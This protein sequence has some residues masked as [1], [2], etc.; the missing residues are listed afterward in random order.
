MDLAGKVLLVTGGRRVGGELARTLALRG[1][2]VALTYHQSRATIERTVADISSAGGRSIA[3]HADLRAAE[4][5]ERAVE[6]T[7]ARLGR[8]DGLINM[9][10]VYRRTPLD[11]LVPE[12]FDAMIGANLAPAYHTALAAA[13]RMLDQESVVDH[14]LKGKIVLVGDW[15]TERPYKDYLPYL[16]A[17]G[18]PPDADTRPGPRACPVDRREP[19]PARDDR[20]APGP[21]RR[22]YRQH[23]GRDPIAASR[24]P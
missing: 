8:I 20:P 21:D 12:D 11:R 23:R 7:V 22:R 16:V 15:A 18:A 19:R 6:E 10:S 24:M 1:A 17:K 14:T 3:I 9:A 5:A 2:S 4:G 13:R